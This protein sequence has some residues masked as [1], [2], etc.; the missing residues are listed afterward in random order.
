MFLTLK[1]QIWAWKALKFPKRKK[2]ETLK[3]L[4][5]ITLLRHFITLN[6]LNDIC[7]FKKNLCFWHTFCL[8]Y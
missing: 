5:D 4:L 2:H 1:R 3:C 8:E 7:Q 6:L